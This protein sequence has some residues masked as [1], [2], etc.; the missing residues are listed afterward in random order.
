MANIFVVNYAIENS[1]RDY[2][3]G[4]MSNSSSSMYKTTASIF[5]GIGNTDK[6]AP[7]VCV[8][9]DNSHEFIPYTQLYETM[10]DVEVREMAYDTTTIGTLAEKVF[11]E[12]YNLCGSNPSNKFVNIGYNYACLNVQTLDSQHTVEGDTLVHK[13][14]FKFIGGLVAS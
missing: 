9:A 10:V 8:N 3:T 1:I 4:S 13:G 12:F 14:T 5:T 6:V 2:L 11:N 7:Y